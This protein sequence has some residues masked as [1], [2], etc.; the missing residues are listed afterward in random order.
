MAFNLWFLLLQ[1]RHIGN[2]ELNVVWSE[3]D[4]DYDISTLRTKV[5]CL[6][7]ILYPLRR[8]FVRVQ[9]KST[10]R[11]PH[12]HTYRVKGSRALTHAC[13]LSSR[14][15]ARAFPVGTTPGW[16]DCT[17]AVS[18]HTRTLDHHQR[19]SGTPPVFPFT[20]PPPPFSLSLS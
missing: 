17:H 2:D 12:E 14:A 4:V 8:G 1:K 7:I 18:G 19:R 3:N 11:T 13:V 5:T 20:P 16:H 10:V 9:L 15:E 6:Y